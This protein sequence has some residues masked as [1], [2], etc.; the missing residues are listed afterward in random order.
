MF[1]KERKAERADELD[2]EDVVNLLNERMSRT[3]RGEVALIIDLGMVH[4]RV[5]CLRSIMITNENPF[6][7]IDNC[8]VVIFF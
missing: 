5:H 1:E 2:G 3:R 4:F 6:S 7:N 8:L